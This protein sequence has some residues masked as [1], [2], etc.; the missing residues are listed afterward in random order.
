M[1]VM[2]GA[3]YWLESSLVKTQAQPRVLTF[4]EKDDGS[5]IELKTGD[6]LVLKLKAQFGTGYSWQISANDNKKLKLVNQSV[7]TET[8]KSESGF[9]TQVF[10]F[11]AKKTGQFEMKL[12]YIRVWEKDAEPLKK[13]GLKIQISKS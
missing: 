2:L 10:K 8:D 9:E 12:Q 7:E 5:Q 13:F 3:G 6:V 1:A 4:T 11:K